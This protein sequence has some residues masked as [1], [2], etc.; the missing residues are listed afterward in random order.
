MIGLRHVVFRPHHCEF[1]CK[2]SSSKG[3]PPPPPPAATT[4]QP[5]KAAAKHLVSED[6][7]GDFVSIQYLVFSR[8]TPNMPIA[9]KKPKKY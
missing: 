5:N 6:I 4:E 1:A 8:V 2:G 7:A 3:A 9:K